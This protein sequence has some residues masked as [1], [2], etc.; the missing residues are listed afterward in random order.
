[1][2]KEKLDMAEVQE[3]F[4]RTDRLV[5]FKKELSSLINRHGIDSLLEVPDFALA[6]AAVAQMEI[7]SSMVNGA[8][9]GRYKP[10]LMM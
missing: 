1:M 3:S 7:C 10:V 9:T 5:A 2:K 8:E 6:H 4:N